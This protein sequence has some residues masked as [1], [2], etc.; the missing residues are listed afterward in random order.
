MTETCAA[1]C[2]SFNK[3]NRS[4]IICSYCPSFAA[5]ASCTERYL[6]DSSQDAHCMSCKKVWPRSFM[7]QNFTQ[8]FMNKTY[9]EHRENVLFEREKALMPATQPYVELE[10]KIRKWNTQKLAASEKLNRARY[11]F[12]RIASR[13]SLDENG[14]VED[15]MTDLENARI[16][17]Y[18]MRASLENCEERLKILFSMRYGNFHSQKIRRVFVRACPA[19]DCK[20]FLSSAWKCGICE[21]TTCSEC[22]ELKMDD[23]VCVP[24]NIETARLLDRDSRPCPKCA[25]MIF[26]IDG[27]DQMWCTACHTA[28]S[29]RHGTIINTIIHNPHYYDYMRANGGLPRNPMDVPC[30]GF[31]DWSIVRQYIP[32]HSYYRAPVHAQH[33]LMPLYDRALA[34]HREM[35]IKYM[36]NELTDEKFKSMIQ[37]DE[38]SRQKNTDV[39]NVLDMF[40]TVMTDLFQKLIITQSAVKFYIEA[41]NIR[42]YTNESLATVSKN[43]SNCRVPIL[44]DDF[45]W[46]M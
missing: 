14:I 34:D 1:C 18:T 43:F 35:R 7:S 38:K 4:K 46:D 19:N 28:F 5:C 30:G 42:K 44:R 10:I 25:S 6:L 36:L 31:P 13:P 20:G 9:K 24:A 15:R 12:T 2:E 29:W 16:E 3:S 33:V 11:M 32:Q 45:H 39:H 8:K 22:H 23:H 27:C 17:M 41:E 26:K 37:R 40:V 21:Q